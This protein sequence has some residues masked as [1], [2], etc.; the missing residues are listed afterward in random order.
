MQ[1]VRIWK[2]GLT[3]LPLFSIFFFCF[4]QRFVTICLHALPRSLEYGLCV[5][6][7]TSI[8]SVCF[9]GSWCW[10]AYFAWR[11]ESLFAEFLKCCEPH[12]W[13]PLRGRYRGPGLQHF[14]SASC[15]PCP[16]PLISQERWL[17]EGADLF[18]YLTHELTCF[19]GVPP[20]P[21]LSIFQKTIFEYYFG[22]T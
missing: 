17:F 3:L 7:F 1:W 2:G 18:A 21:P 19:V 14:L 15:N 12:L 8:I 20:I 5:C 10:Y 4:F 22:S 11:I 16:R 13:T 6:Y 9:K